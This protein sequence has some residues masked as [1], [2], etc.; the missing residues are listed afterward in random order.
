MSGAIGIGV[1]DI[2]V[3]IVGND[4]QSQG[5]EVQNVMTNANELIG[6]VAQSRS[7]VIGNQLIGESVPDAIEPVI[8]QT[9]E[10]ISEITKSAPDTTIEPIMSQ[11]SELIGEVT[12][13]M[14]EE[15]DDT[16]EPVFMKALELINQIIEPMPHG[17]TKEDLLRLILNHVVELKEPYS[18][19]DRIMEAARQLAIEITT[20]PESVD[21]DSTVDQTMEAARKLAV[22]ITKQPE[23]LD[24]DS[25]VDQTMEAARQ[26]A[27]EITTQ[28]ESLDN[29]NIVDQTMEAARQ[30]AVEITKQ[31]ESLDND[32]IVD[33]TMEAA[34]QLAIEITKQPES[35]LDTD[36]NTDTIIDKTLQQSV[37]L[38]EQILSPEE[39][40]EPGTPWD[41]SGLKMK[42][43]FANMKLFKDRETSE[44][45]DINEYDN[46]DNENNINTHINGSTIKVNGDAI[47]SEHIWWVPLP[48]TP[49]T[50]AK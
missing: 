11:A 43:P 45:I 47:K 12:P 28:P 3:D 41:L 14:P 23:S 21:F 8:R 34:R 27:V 9:G 29:D 6:E 50:V 48:P 44:H 42:N 37:D 24:N 17:F 46:E 1:N 18:A 39:V 10:L 30:L 38:L 36:K 7:E 2:G 15:M 5:S 19:I 35:V 25:T 4:T 33:Q 40:V 13:S 49:T 22:E 20:Q 26:L 32:N 16:I 31:P